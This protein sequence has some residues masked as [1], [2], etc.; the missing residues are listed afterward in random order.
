MSKK[1]ELRANRAKTQKRTM[2]LIIILVGVVAVII[3]ALIIVPQIIANN[4]PVADVI[5]PV[6]NPRPQ[7]NGLSMGDPNAPVKIVEYADFQCPACQ[8]FLTNVEPTIVDK[9][10]K[11]GKVY[12]SFLP[13]SFIDNFVS[14]GYESK[15]AAQAAYCASD[16]G[17]FW[18][19]H[20]MLY[21]NQDP[22]GENK[23]AFSS[24]RLALMAEKLNLD[25]KDFNSCYSSGKF[26]Q[27]VLDDKTSADTLGVDQ[28]PS[29][30]INGKLVV[31]KDFNDML[32]QIDAAVTAA[33]K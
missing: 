7:A 21:A 15:A 23:G 3:A 1:D 19:F 26:T 9:Y 5:V 20:D 2:T 30:S 33:G 14:N 25:T 24:K 32:A 8:Y 16:Q 18:E 6:A 4:K 17:K 27:Q 22:T 31:A 28:T 11:T 13:D 29:I 10:V 12:Y